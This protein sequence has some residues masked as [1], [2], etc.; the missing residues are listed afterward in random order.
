MEFVC[1]VDDGMPIK[2]ERKS[3]MPPPLME[4]NIPIRLVCDLVGEAGDSQNARDSLV[5]FA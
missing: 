4:P 2:R 5:S 3:C 1:V